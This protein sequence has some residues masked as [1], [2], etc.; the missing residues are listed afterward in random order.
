MLAE[1]AENYSRARNEDLRSTGHVL[2]FFRGYQNHHGNA[3]HIR[4]SAIANDI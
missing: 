3:S 4:I 2:Q 1:A